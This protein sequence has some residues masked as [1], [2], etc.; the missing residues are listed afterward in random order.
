MLCFSKQ[1]FAALFWRVI[2]S[3]RTIIDKYVKNVSGG[4]IYACFVDFKKAFDSIWHDGLFVRMLENKINGKF[5]NLIK[6][7]YSKT[8]CFIKLGAKKTKTFEYNR[9]VRQGCIL[10]PLLFNL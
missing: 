10:S 3:V 2:Y 5:Y 4:K 6:C 8:T 9:G 7:L 1:W